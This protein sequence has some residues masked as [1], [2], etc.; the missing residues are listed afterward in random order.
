MDSLQEMIICSAVFVSEAHF[1]AAFPEE[2]GE[3]VRYRKCP[4]ASCRLLV[5]HNVD[6]ENLPAILSR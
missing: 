3:V 5:T 2:G 1:F 6:T 4:R